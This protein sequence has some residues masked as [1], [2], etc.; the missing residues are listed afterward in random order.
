M[1]I[2][3][4]DNSNS[5][6]G[7]PFNIFR[8]EVD[9][10]GNPV[11]QPMTF[12]DYTIPPKGQYRLKF[13]GFAEP[14]EVTETWEGE[15]KTKMETKLEIEI[16]DGPGKGHKFIVNWVTFSLGDRANAF[17]LYV[18]TM[19]NGDK[20]AAPATRNWDDMIGKEFEGYVTNPKMKEDGTPARAALSWDTLTP[21]REQGEGYDP[22]KKPNAA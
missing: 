13:T 8:G 15:T 17:N 1:A 20:K 16:A 3:S 2:F 18:A 6:G 4:F 10:A 11:F 7:G 12:D 19:C 14:K 21:G 22:F 9:G 5:G